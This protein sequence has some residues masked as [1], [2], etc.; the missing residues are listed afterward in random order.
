MYLTLASFAATSKKI[1]R[2]N[3]RLEKKGMPL[4]TYTAD[5]KYM[6]MKDIFPKHDLPKFYGEIM[7][8]VIDFSF[9]SDF[10]KFQLET[11][12]EFIAV[13]DHNENLIHSFVEG[14]DV[15]RFR[16]R[17]VCDHCKTKR[18]RSKTVIL[19]KGEELF[20]IGTKCLSDFFQKDVNDFV[21][22]MELFSSNHA[23]SNDPSDYFYG[24]SS[25]AHCMVE[26]KTILKFAVASVHKYGYVPTSEPNSTRQVVTESIFGGNLR[27][28]YTKE[29]EEEAVKILKWM[30]TIPMNVSC[31]LSNLRQIADNGFASPKNFGYVCYAV[32]EYQKE[33][34]KKVETKNCSEYFGNIGEKVTLEVVLANKHE[35][36]SY[37]GYMCYHTFKDSEGHTFVWM[38]SSRPAMKVGNTYKIKASIKEHSEY[39][40]EKQ[41][42]ITRV[43]TI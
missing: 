14:V 11:G 35:T 26:L 38:T 42:F 3:K 20:Q 8:N 13:V 5:E 27:V 19:R 41:T 17:A 37:Y 4:I 33:L 43:K 7:V 39:K 22:A 24:G 31:F 28:S 1:K 23:M 32:V 18:N 40:G 12:Y 29:D 21:K 36:Q 9:T 15:E 2:L 25:H 10:E 16:T 34:A 6:A 30:K